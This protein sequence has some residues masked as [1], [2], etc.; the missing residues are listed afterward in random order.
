MYNLGIPSSFKA[1]ID[2]IGRV[3]KT[4]R[5]TEKGPVGL[6]GDKKVMVLAA[7][8]GLYANTPADTQTP[9][10]QSIF[11]YFGISDQTFV[12]AEGLNISPEMK[13][14]GMAGAVAEIKALF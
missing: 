3:G 9:Y 11:G 13:E 5:Y 7:R 1:Y 2:H 4:F 14:K 10:I 12:Y 6:A 8:G